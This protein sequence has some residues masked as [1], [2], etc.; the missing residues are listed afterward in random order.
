MKH[1]IIAAGIMLSFT[2]N[3]QTNIAVGIAYTKH[4]G[5]GCSQFTQA[6]GYEYQ[7]GGSSSLAAM[8]DAVE[9]KLKSRYSGADVMVSTTSSKS[10]ACIIYYNKPIDGYGCTKFSY[11]VGF[12]NSQ[13]EAKE[14]AVKEMKL[15]YDDDN[16]QI[17]RYIK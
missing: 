3:A 2:A 10:V 12:G 9:E 17:E 15:Y 11:A 5:Y 7:I 6:V 4:N 16:W 8:R 14:A 1:I 13:S